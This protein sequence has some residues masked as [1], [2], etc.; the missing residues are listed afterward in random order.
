MH[1]LA[2][3][4]LVLV[5]PGCSSHDP[6]RPTDAAIDGVADLCHAC[7]TGQLCV[8]RYDGTCLLQ[9]E[10]VARTVD[11]PGTSSACSAECEAAYCPS[12]YQ[13]HIRP[14]CGGQPPPPGIFT[15]YGP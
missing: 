2:A 6:Q 13:C 5:F 11:C 12:P 3:I 8:A 9:V 4:A 10:C 15:C 14:G 1:W 7:G